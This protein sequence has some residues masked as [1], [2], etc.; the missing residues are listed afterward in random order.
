MF[1]LSDLTF[2]HELCTK[3]CF[4]QHRITFC[5]YVIITGHL[6]MRIDQTFLIVYEN[7]IY[8]QW[9]ININ[10]NVYYIQKVHLTV[11]SARSK[12]TMQMQVKYKFSHKVSAAFSCVRYRARYSR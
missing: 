3:Y 6:R 2:S 12:R 4:I 1:T 11:S 8:V 10:F 7:T 9:E 5:T